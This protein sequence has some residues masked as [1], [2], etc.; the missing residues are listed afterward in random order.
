MGQ[1][2]AR[3]GDMV[4]QQA[5]HCHA[6]IHPPAPT[7]TPVPH[8]PMPL[9]IVSGAAT[10]LIGGAPAARAMDT[11]APCMMIPCVP[12]GPGMIA[13]GSATVLIEGM[14]AARLNDTTSHPSCVAP[15]PS[16]TGMITGPGC[17]TVLIGG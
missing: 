15:I 2:A 3:I 5:P 12:G 11:T 6:P 16:P 13:K 17:P 10:V 4:L 8:P 14:P 9:A 1:P 7:P